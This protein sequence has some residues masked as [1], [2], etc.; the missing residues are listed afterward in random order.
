MGNTNKPIIF[1]G[2]SYPKYNNAI[3]MMGG[4]NKRR[5]VENLMQIEGEVFNCERGLEIALRSEKAKKKLMGWGFDIDT[6]DMTKRKN[7]TDVYQKLESMGELKRGFPSDDFSISQLSNGDNKPNIIDIDEVEDG[8]DFYNLVFRI[9]NYNYDKKKIHI[10]WVIEDFEDVKQRNLNSNDG[11]VIS[12]IDLMVTHEG[13]ARLMLEFLNG[14]LNLSEYMDGDIWLV[15]GED[16]IVQVKKA[17][18]PIDNDKFDDRILNI[19]HERVPV[20]IGGFLLNKRRNKDGVWEEIV[21]K[22]PTIQQ[23]LGNVSCSNMVGSDTI[24]TTS[25]DGD[26]YKVATVKGFENNISNRVSEN[27]YDSVDLNDFK[28]ELTHYI[29]DAIN[30]KLERER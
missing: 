4:T 6:L 14:S 15:L 28:S 22:T 19:I 12:D 1:G 29:V 8:I 27:E 5:V 21:K 2:E 13:T 18:S 25:I 26:S 7:I 23:F 11:R 30:E 20:I 24:F 9:K 10:V 17:G 3:I 16:D